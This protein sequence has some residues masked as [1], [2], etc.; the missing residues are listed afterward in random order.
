M[1]LGC[2]R[3]SVTINEMIFNGCV[4]QGIESDIILADYCPDVVRI[5]KC[6]VQPKI[7]SAAAEGSRITI[8]G[9]ACVKIFYLTE[10]KKI[11]CHP[12]SVPFQKNIELKE[13]YSGCVVNVF[14]KVDY[15]N[16]RAVSSRRIDF[17]GALSLQ[18]KAV[19][20]C[21][22]EMV[23]EAQEMGVQ[24]RR[25]TCRCNQLV[26]Q[27]S[28]RFTIQETLE[29]GYGKPS[30]QTL[31]DCRS[32]ALVTDFKPIGGKVITKGEL[33]L[34]FTYYCPENKLQFMEYSL[35]IS[36]ICD[37]EGV[38]EDSDCQVTYEV[39]SC[40]VQPQPTPDGEVRSLELE[41][42][43]KCT[44]QAHRREE[45]IHISDCYSTQYECT[46]STKHTA[47]A[48][49]VRMVE[50]SR[51]FKESITVPD[52]VSAVGDLWCSLEDVQTE[53]VMDK[54]KLSVKLN[55]CLLAYDN[56]DNPELFDR[57]EELT[58][59]IEAGAA[60]E[61][62]L[63]LPVVQAVDSSYSIQG[64][65]RME[66]RCDLLIQGCIYQME[67]RLLLKGV[68]VDTDRP[69]ETKGRSPLTIYYADQGES[70]WE[71]AKRYNTVPD[72][73]LEENELHQD[74]LDSRRML[75]IPIL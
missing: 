6:V 31:L 28:S 71:I 56:E 43:V 32:A 16:C 37:V 73:I 41:C 33:H 4:E 66:I 70:V 54:M 5:L 58:Y 26:G 61:G 19:C 9:I 74:V 59:E 12:F 45:T 8:D 52:T 40:G 42:V 36:Q 39:I 20:C 64:S 10:Q 23:C 46:S 62:L 29:L 67:Q 30:L 55:I 38:T 14:P 13:S 22:E 53:Q 65:D 1:E 60:V 7:E 27:A 35:P 18:V 51:S 44:I 2:S 63:F 68:D 11:H 72:S 75:L 34:Q 21:K 49:L 17:K 69:K 3:Q 50:E 47:A 48:N 25:E 15:A 57:T 24:L